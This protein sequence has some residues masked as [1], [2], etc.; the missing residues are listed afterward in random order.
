LDQNPVDRPGIA[1]DRLREWQ[2]AFLARWSIRNGVA[3]FHPR[4][5][6]GPNFRTIGWLTHLPGIRTCHHRWL[7]FGPYVRFVST[8]DL[9]HPSW[10]LVPGGRFP[11]LK[12]WAEVYSP[13]GATP[14]GPQTAT[15]TLNKYFVPGYYRAVPPGQKH[16]PIETARI[17]WLKP[18]AR[19]FV[20][21]L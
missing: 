18:W 12:P 6:G 14:F 3:R 11:G 19:F 4:K 2:P 17:M 20:S 5:R 16:S 13:F 1:A 15:L 9:A 7:Y 21:K 8:F 10:R